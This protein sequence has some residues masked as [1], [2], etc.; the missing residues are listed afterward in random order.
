MTKIIG[1]CDCTKYGDKS[2]L[3]SLLSVHLESYFGNTKVLRRHK[4]SYGYARPSM[5]VDTFT[6]CMADDDRSRSTEHKTHFSTSAPNGDSQT[7]TMWGIASEKPILDWSAV[8]KTLTF[9]HSSVIDFLLIETDFDKSF[10]AEAKVSSVTD[11]LVV[12][13]HRVRQDS[14]CL[15]FVKSAVEQ[16]EG[17]RIGVIVDTGKCLGE[18]FDIYSHL[19]NLVGPM[20]NTAISFLGHLPQTKNRDKY[21]TLETMAL[22]NIAF[23]LLNL[24][25][26]ANTHS[27]SSGLFKGVLH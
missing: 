14:D 19:E 7:I 27:I 1:F 9:S 22:Q 10:L 5:S 8:L 26:E 13:D 16:M 24:K 17:C 15:Q 3:A 4:D 2:R 11:I 23:G 21:S 25:Y 18:A 12:L 20:K 6:T